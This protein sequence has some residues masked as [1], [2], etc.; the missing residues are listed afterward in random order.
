MPRTRYNDLTGQKFGRLMVKKRISKPGGPV[1]WLCLCDCGTE[2]VVISANLVNK[3][4]KS[5]GCIRSE[6]SSLLRKKHGMTNSPTY[7][8]WAGMRTRTSNPK[9]TNYDSYGG[10][11]IKCCERWSSFEKFFEDMGERPH[12]MTLDR[13]DVNGNYEPSN[14]RWASKD[15]QAKNKRQCKLINKDA[16]LN[17]LKTQT[18]LTEGQQT[19]IANNFFKN[20]HK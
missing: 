11:G 14:C 1:K 4:T 5:C 2:S 9:S 10:R 8:V 3:T 6:R 18:Y 19:M 15:E 20:N 13:I 17:F 12:G 7:K 16:L